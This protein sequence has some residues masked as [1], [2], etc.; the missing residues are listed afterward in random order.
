M[1]KD[2]IIGFI[3]GGNRAEAL[4]R[5]LMEGGVPAADLSVAEQQLVE[6]AKALSQDG[7]V[8]LVEVLGSHPR[9]PGNG[10]AGILVEDG[11]N[12]EIRDNIIASTLTD[13]WGLVVP[14]LQ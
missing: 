4:I 10:R 12:N 13:G 3:G 1:L 14:S 7:D 2:K 8:H 6:I 5:G 9:H 11:D